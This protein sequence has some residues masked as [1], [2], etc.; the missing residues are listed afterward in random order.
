MDE[1]IER[2]VSIA[3]INAAVAKKAVGI[4]VG[5]L[6]SKGLSKGALINRILGAT[7]A[8]WSD[9]GDL[10]RLS[11]GGVMAVD[12]CLMSPSLGIPHIRNVV[13]EL[14]HLHD[15]VG[16]DG[17]NHRGGHMSLVICS[18]GLKRFA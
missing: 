17:Q 7:I 15:K 14:F 18:L 3:E 12:V 9:G 16:A 8:T 1:L 6:R 13:H 4:F 11:G 5:V 10:S 2:L